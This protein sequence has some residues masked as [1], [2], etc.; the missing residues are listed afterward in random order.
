MNKNQLAAKVLDRL[1][2]RYPDLKTALVWKTPWQLLVATVLSAQCTDRQVNK[3]TP[4]FFQKWPT[5]FDL[6]QASPEEVAQVIRSAGFYRAKSKSLVGAANIIVK[7]F[8]GKVPS[9]M[10]DLVSLPGVGRKTANIVLSGAFGINKGIAVDTHVKRISFRLGLTESG[11]PEVIEKVLM[12]LF[13]REEWANVNHMLVFFGRDVCRAR[14]P[15]CCD[16]ELKDICHQNGV[17]LDC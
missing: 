5:P 9:C 4:L 16:C 11:K 13:P 14:K 17:Q 10:Q 7:D 3:I 1:K 8:G 12:P 15:A 2:A 6:V